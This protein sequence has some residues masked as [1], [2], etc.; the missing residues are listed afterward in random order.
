ME[1]ALKTIEER[2]CETTMIDVLDLRIYGCNGCNCCFAT[3]TCAFHD[4]LAPIYDILDNADGI[5]SAMPVYFYG[6][7]GQMKIFI[8]RF[9]AIWAR[10]YVLHQE[11]ARIRPG[12]LISIAGSK[13]QK[14]FDGL[15]MS[16]KYF[17]NVQGI[18]LVEPLL[19]RNWD[20]EPDE[21]PDDFI[22][23]AKEYGEKFWDHLQIGG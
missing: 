20:G 9:Q 11:P 5:I 22:K 1:T 4:D 21:M 19:I 8:D 15:I 14:V 23:Q 2:G 12:G 17:Y 7:P 10:R 18:N 16:V 13:G 6:V 3:G